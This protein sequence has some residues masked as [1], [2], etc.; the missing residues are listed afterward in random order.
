MH[1]ASQTDTDTHRH[2]DAYRF[3]HARHHKYMHAQTHTQHTHTHTFTCI[4][5]T[6]THTGTQTHTQNK[7]INMYTG[8]CLHTCRDTKRQAHAQS[9]GT[10]HT[11][12]PPTHTHMCKQINMHKH[13]HKDPHTLAQ[14][15]TRA[16]RHIDTHPD[17]ETPTHTHRCEHGPTGFALDM[18]CGDVL[19]SLCAAL[20]K[21]QRMWHGAAKVVCAARPWADGQ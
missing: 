3:A 11:D 15:C 18:P 14:S 6:Q 19:R 2:T 4:V 1:T 5:D 10:P 7:H 20:G 12:A 16:H 13:R 21:H 8:A 9:T 17:T